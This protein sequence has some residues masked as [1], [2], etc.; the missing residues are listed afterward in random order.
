MLSREEAGRGRVRVTTPTVVA[1]PNI[2][3]TGKLGRWGLCMCVCVCVCVCVCECVCEF[4]TEIEYR[5][6]M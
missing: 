4:M 6:P 3:T 5:V 2:S 1:T